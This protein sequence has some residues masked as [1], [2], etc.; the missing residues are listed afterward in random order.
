MPFK[1]LAVAITVVF[2]CACFASPLETEQYGEGDIEDQEIG[3][4]NDLRPVDDNGR[5]A[6]SVSAAKN[7]FGRYANI[8]MSK[9]LPW[10]KRIPVLTGAKL[11]SK[12]GNTK[13]W[14]KTG[15]RAQFQKDLDLINIRRADNKPNVKTISSTGRISETC[16]LRLESKNLKGQWSVDIITYI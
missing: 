8:I 10:Q 15:G 12:R 11:V 14:E 16:R 6:R 2:V 5:N 1:A 7:V 13:Y 9:I 3:Y 4:L